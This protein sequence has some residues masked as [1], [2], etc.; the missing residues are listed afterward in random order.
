MKVPDFRKIKLKPSPT[1]M[2]ILIK[3][4]LGLVFLFIVVAIC[5]TPTAL[6]VSGAI[7]ILC[8]LLLGAYMAGD[9]IYNIYKEWRNK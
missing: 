4:G 7:A 9:I 5:L 3:I 2:D 8:V 1:V 6:F